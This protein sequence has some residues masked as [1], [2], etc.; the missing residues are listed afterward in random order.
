MFDIARLVSDLRGAGGTTALLYT[1]DN[2]GGIADDGPSD[3]VFAAFPLPPASL[4]VLPFFEPLPPES[5]AL[6]QCN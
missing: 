5:A 3:K 2:V 4:S 1:G 6:W